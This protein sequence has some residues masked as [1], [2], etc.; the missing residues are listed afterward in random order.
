MFQLGGIEALGSI[1]V[2]GACQRY[3]DFRFV[4]G[5]CGIS[6][7]PFALERL[8]AAFA[9]KRGDFELDLSGKP[10]EFWHEHGHSTYQDEQAVATVLELVGE[11]RVIWGSDYPH[12]DSVWPESQAVIERNLRD[13]PEEKRRKIICENAGRLYGFIR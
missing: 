2:S 7:I 9:E 1:L 8:D 4:L 11:D 10:S 6:W 12:P 13:L 3:P 5:E